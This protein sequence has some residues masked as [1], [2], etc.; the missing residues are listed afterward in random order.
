MK[1]SIHK[2]VL[3]GLTISLY[4]IALSAC[5]EQRPAPKIEAVKSL[6]AVLKIS[7]SEDV[8]N[9]F[10]DLVTLLHSFEYVET[11]RGFDKIIAAEPR[12]AMGYWGKAMSIWHPLWVP[13]SKTELKR[14]IQTLAQTTT[15]KKSEKEL[16][17]INALQAYYAS[18]DL[19]TNKKRARAYANAMADVSAKYP[20]DYEIE[21]FYALGLLS[22]ADARDKTYANQHKAG[23]ILKKL[24]ADHPLHPGVLHYTIHAYD[25][26]GLAHN[27]LD[28][29]NAYAGSAKNSAH[30]Q[31]MPSHIFTR[32]GLWEK[33]LASNHDSTKSAADYTVSAD[34]P[35]HYDEGLHSIDYLMYAMLQTG[36]DA[37][38]KRLLTRL[39][40]IEK[41]DTEGFKVAFSFAAAPARYVLERRAWE[42]ARELPLMRPDFLWDNFEWARAINVFARGLGA[43]RSGDLDQAKAE[44]AEISDIQKGLPDTLM[45][46]ISTEVQVQRDVVKSWIMLAEGKSTEA[47][48]LAL[49]AAELEDAL[50]KHPVT[51]GEVL[52]AREL[53]AD[54]LLETEK[55]P[56]ALVQYKKVLTGSPNRLNALVGAAH[57]A[58]K[59]G[60]RKTAT[61]FTT[62]ARKQTSAGDRVID[63]PK[64]D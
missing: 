35:G 57:A 19:S 12:C 59:M 11:S 27:A 7:C 5:G 40:K 36:R 47:L 18:T 22:A 60:D 61:S 15:L 34:L 55:Y 41:T 58:A 8:Q 33:S 53:Y 24:K 23:G 56:Q 21:I 29:A 63:F 26:P 52:P 44:L 64:L 50:D 49:S 13:P 32:L 4:P 54:M 6:P 51:P 9:E 17:L 46:Y 30:A 25:Y 20:D 48:A 3:W 31:H 2:S 10:S 1:S 16:D 38:A 28:E 62:T 43:A 37:E 42:E 39:G 14:G 45:P